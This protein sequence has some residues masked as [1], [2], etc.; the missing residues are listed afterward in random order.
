M[1]TFFSRPS[2]STLVLTLG[3]L[4]GTLGL[5]ALADSTVFTGTRSNISPGGSPGGRCAPSITVSFSPDSF[6]ASGTS[7]LGAYSFTAS[8]CVAG[9]P[10]GP[11]DGG[12]FVWNFGDGTLVGTYGGQL[13]AAAPGSFTVSENIVFTGGTGRFLGATGSAVAN[14][15][16]SFGTF[17]GTPV[18][19]GETTFTGQLALA[20]VPEPASWALLLAGLAVVAARARRTGAGQ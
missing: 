14:G 6:A 20:P 3:V 18:S 11:Y 2:R 10:P 13:S 17:N 7:N 15:T 12:Q 16:L 19:F 4:G 1:S 5:P 9:L 8:H